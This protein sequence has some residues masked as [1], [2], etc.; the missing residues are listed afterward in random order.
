MGTFF[1]SQFV[2]IFCFYLIQTHAEINIYGMIH[3]I[4]ILVLHNI[5]YL[6]NQLTVILINLNIISDTILINLQLQH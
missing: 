1:I 4:Q 5:S 6:N 2:T 3:L